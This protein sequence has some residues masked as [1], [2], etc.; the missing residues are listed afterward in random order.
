[1]SISSSDSIQ[2][3]VRI[4][5]GLSV[6]FAES[7]E[8]ETHALML[9]PWPE[10]LLAFEPTR[11]RLAEHTHLVAIDLPGFG[12]YERR[13]ELLSPARWGSSRAEEVGL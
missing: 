7:E 10:S 4:I 6:R 1:M 12:H 11:T 5:D 3:D 13:D 8:R 9:T 2:T